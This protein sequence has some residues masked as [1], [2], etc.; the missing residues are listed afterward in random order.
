MHICTN[1][2]PHCGVK[3]RDFDQLLNFVALHTSPYSLITA[4]LGTKE[5]SVLCQN[6]PPPADRKRANLMTI[7]RTVD[8]VGRPHTQNPNTVE[9][10][11]RTSFGS[12]VVSVLDSGAEGPGSNRSLRQTVHTHRASDHQ[13]AKLAAAL[14]MVAGVTAGLAKSN[15]SQP[16]G[17]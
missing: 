5:R 11:R 4:K 10:S 9:F 14:L 17:L 6:S 7:F 16:P 15:G 12:R 3:E 13:A 8:E 1:T 2:I